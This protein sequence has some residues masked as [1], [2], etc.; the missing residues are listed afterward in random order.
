MKAENRQELKLGNLVSASEVQLGRLVGVNKTSSH[1][2]LDLL[3]QDLLS[4]R[5]SATIEPPLL[6]K[7]ADVNTVR[8]PLGSL[9][10]SRELPLPQ[11]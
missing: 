5:Y 11:R 3:V 8:T 6:L 9:I 10:H 2:A 7:M 4:S 1:A